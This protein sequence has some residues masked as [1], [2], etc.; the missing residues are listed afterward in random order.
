MYP[1]GKLFDPLEI[2]LLVSD[3]GPATYRLPRLQPPTRIG[4]FWYIAGVKCPYRVAG[5]A[6]A[7]GA[8]SE[9][10]KSAHCEFSLLELNV[11]L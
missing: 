11:V 6:S 1:G 7:L 9:I 2:G 3:A 4:R 10:P 5:K 8:G